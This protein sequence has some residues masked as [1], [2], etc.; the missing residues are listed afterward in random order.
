MKPQKLFYLLSK[1]KNKQE[2][3]QILRKNR[4]PLY[5]DTDKKYNSKSITL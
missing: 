2:F 4:I 1:A 5:I 3:I